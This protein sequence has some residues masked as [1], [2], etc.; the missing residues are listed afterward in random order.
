MTDYEYLLE[1]IS[2]LQIN[3]GLNHGV[4]IEYDKDVKVDDETYN[5]TVLTCKFCSGMVVCTPTIES[6]IKE[7]PKD[8]LQTKFRQKF[9]AFCL[10]RHVAGDWG[11]VCLEDFA[12]N[13]F[14]LA[15]GERLM[16]VYE[17]DGQKIWIITEWN[18]SV[19]TVLD[20]MD[21]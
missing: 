10:M 1:T 20:P 5:S 9:V 7:N 3:Y 15:E 16:S 21:Y 12:E 14:S 2:N 18:R 6:W 19:T 4:K 11:T 8:E 17:Y 13:E